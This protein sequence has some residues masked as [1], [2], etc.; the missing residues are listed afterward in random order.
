MFM[1]ETGSAFEHKLADYENEYELISP[2]FTPTTDLDTNNGTRGVDVGAV[3]AQLD[4]L[5][6]SFADGDDAA[7]FS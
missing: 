1:Y 6:R 7:D 5:T 3:F 4:E 2:A